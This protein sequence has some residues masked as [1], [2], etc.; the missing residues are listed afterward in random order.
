MSVYSVS[1]NMQ[2][3]DNAKW[4]GIGF[5]YDRNTESLPVLA[6]LFKDIE[7]GKKIFNSIYNRLLLNILQVV[8]QKYG[9]YL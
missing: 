8:N 7:E 3:W 6:L 5:I 2:W 9:R 1:S 4:S